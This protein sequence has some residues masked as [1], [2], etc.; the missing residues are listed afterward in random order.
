MVGAGRVQLFLQF[1]VETTLLFLFSTIL[2]LIL[3]YLLVPLFNQ[4]SGKELIV[5]YSDPQIWK[6]IGITILATLIISS[7]YPAVLL[8]SFEPLKALKGK[9]SARISDAVF[10][11]ALVVLQFGFSMILICGTLVIGKQLSYIRSK[12]LGYDKDHV[13]AM[14]LIEMGKHFDAVKAELMKQPGITNVTCATSNIINY[15]GHTGDNNWDG[16][17]K[18]ETLM[19]CPIGIDKD[20]L[21]FF[22]MEL[23]EGSG[24]TGSPGDSMHFILNETAIK[25]ARIKDPIGKK[26]KLWQTEGTIVGV[27]KDFHFA[28]MRHKIE[29]LIFYA[30]SPG[31]GRL[32]IKTTGNDAPKAIAAAETQWKKYNAGFTFNYT[33][34]DEAFNNLYKSEQRTGFLYQLFAAIAVFISCLGLLGLA[35]YTAQVRTREIG[36]RKVLGASVPGIIRLLTGD[37]IKLVMI[38]IVVATPVAWYV[39]NKWLQDFA[40]KINIGWTVFAVAGFI[41]VLVAL[42]AVSFQSIRAAIANPVKSLRTE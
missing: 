27:V 36:I 22:K 23:K 16:K 9:L 10:R 33:F 35:A 3:I 38:A 28:S 41:A 19:L 11:K 25:A 7:I 24:F 26:F 6:V 42:F 4:V 1:I 29:P 30:K 2:A 37:F 39:M 8:S 12:Q 15:D 40:Y 14:G 13:L 17:E 18:G 34:L 21:S 32:Y 31:Y 20:F 5:N